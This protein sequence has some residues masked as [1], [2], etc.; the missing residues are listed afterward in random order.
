MATV[1]LVISYSAILVASVSFEA[2]GGPDA[3]PALAL[4]FALVP[5]VFMT[6]AFVSG[7]RRGAGAVVKAMGL[8]VLV[9]LPVS[10]IMQDAITGLVAGYG[11]GGVVSLRAEAVHS[12]KARAVAVALTSIYVAVLVRVIIE[13]GLIAGATLSLVSIG[14]ADSFVEFRAARASQ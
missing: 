12:W 7:H 13:A 10:A 4:G 2:E 11:A 8:F 14:I 9:A 5:F 1:L 3:A 6:L